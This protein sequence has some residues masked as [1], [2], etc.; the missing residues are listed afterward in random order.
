[1]RLLLASIAA[2]IAGALPFAFA[3]HAA[4]L[5]YGFLA[6]FLLVVVIGLPAYA[7]F[8]RKR[9]LSPLR[10]GVFGGV[11]GMVAGA[12]RPL[13]GGSGAELSE[14]AFGMGLVALIGALAGAAF[15]YFI[16]RQSAWKSPVFLGLLGLYA[17][18]IAATLA[19]GPSLSAE[20]PPDDE[21]GIEQV[22]EDGRIER[23]IG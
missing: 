12:A 10:C 6:S 17:A 21:P 7:L 2:V 5:V 19:F 14:I 11:V 8:G 23:I 20:Q 18:L 16:T 9:T 4:L 1:M 3:I 13:L 22:D 15:G